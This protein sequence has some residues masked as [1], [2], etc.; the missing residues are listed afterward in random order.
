MNV[1]A[2]VGTRYKL[3]VSILLIVL[4]FPRRRMITYDITY[5][6]SEY[7]YDREVPTA[8]YI[9]VLWTVNIFD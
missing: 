5:F 2:A 8:L 9:F 1:N 7:N 3:H 6:N 4:F